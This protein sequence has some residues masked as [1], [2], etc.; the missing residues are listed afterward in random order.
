MILTVQFKFRFVIIMIETTLII[1]SL[2]VQDLPI[3]LKKDP[4]VGLSIGWS[5][6][7]RRAGFPGD[8]SL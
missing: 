1:Y 8:V 5:E 6:P 7:S 2:A 4:L 3:A